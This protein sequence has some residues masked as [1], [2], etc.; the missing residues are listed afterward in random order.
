MDQS[1]DPAILDAL[2]SS[3]VGPVMDKPVE[4]V[5]REMG[6]PP[7]PDISFPLEFP[8]PALDLAA[9]ARPLTDLASSFG[10]GHF[11]AAPEVDPVQVLNQVSSVIQT[12][13]RVGS[14]A[15]QL[16]GGQWQGAGAE[17]AAIKQAQVGTDSAAV[18]AQSAMTSQ[19]VAAAAGSV[20]RGALTLA[21]IIA[22][23][24]T[25]VAVAAPF[26]TTGGG[27]VFLAAATAESL[28]E[29]L[30]VVAQ[31]RAEL[32]V[33]SAQMTTTGNK[34]PVT[35]APDSAQAMQL[36]SQV[37][38]IAPTV[39]DAATAG[40]EAVM[41][42]QP[43]TLT[44]T[45]LAQRTPATRPAA[46]PGGGG[47]PGGAAFSAAGTSPGQPSRALAPWSGSTAAGSTGSPATSSP[48]SGASTP[49]GSPARGSGPALMS[50]GGATGALSRGTGDSTAN[51]LQGQLVTGQHGNEVVGELD[52]ATPAVIG[53]DE[54]R[55][56]RAIDGP[57]PDKALTL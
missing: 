47:P 14:S 2:R 9:L 57:P 48:A 29:A 25:S 45:A 50:P 5:L 40:A 8:M 51:G 37:L 54:H 13:A 31:T 36:L 15:M 21:A 18:A 39:L 17:G 7:L 1:L 49:T 53:A 11:P 41:T 16:A 12:A 33:H 44:D 23:Y 43:R 42:K 52:T 6:L 22:K 4:Q 34:V 30:A 38:Q 56:E 55:G 24:L 20:S 3:P 26:L 46:P 19:Q 10:T 32:T 27:Q 35:G 28:A